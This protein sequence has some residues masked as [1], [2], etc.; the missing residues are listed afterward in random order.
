[1]D[2]IRLRKGVGVP[3][4]N[5]STKPRQ[6]LL[7]G[8]YLGVAMTSSRLWQQIGSH[9]NSVPR[10]DLGGDN[11]MLLYGDKVRPKNQL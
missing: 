5:S 3:P 2:S 6:R 7:C 4:K 8:S 9:A 11:N 10:H 1:M